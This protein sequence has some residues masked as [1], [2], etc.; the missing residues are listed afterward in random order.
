[1]TTQPEYAFWFADVGWG[2]ENRGTEPDIEVDI[3]PQESAAGADPQLQKAIQVATEQLKVHHPLRP[4]VATR[5]SRA[6]IP[7]PPRT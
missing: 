2:L 5:A 4:D 3:S 6:G 1:M 7:F